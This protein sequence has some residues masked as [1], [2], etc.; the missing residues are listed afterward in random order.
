MKKILIFTIFM[1]IY[2]LSIPVGAAEEV[3]SDV[4]VAGAADGVRYEYKPLLRVVAEPYDRF[5]FRMRE[6]MDE[7]NS[8]IGE[9]EVQA[10]VFRK[11]GTCIYEV[12]PIAGPISQYAECS[13]MRVLGEA[14]RDAWGRQLEQMIQTV[15]DKKDSFKAK[16]LLDVA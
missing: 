12:K 8:F 9:Y 14:K 4:Y 5:L 10:I 16:H 13:K 7:D 15:I 6:Y 1:F 11:Y 3:N 2:F